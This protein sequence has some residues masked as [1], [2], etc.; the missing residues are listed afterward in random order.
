MPKKAG[1]TLSSRE[2]S[3]ETVTWLSELGAVTPSLANL[4]FAFPTFHAGSIVQC[5]NESGSTNRQVCICRG[6]GAAFFRQY[7]P[8]AALPSCGPCSTLLLVRH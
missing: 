6:H 8:R 3:D 2:K 1:S 7:G 4:S 5:V